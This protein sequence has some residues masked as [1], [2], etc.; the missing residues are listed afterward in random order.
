M[1]FLASPC[2]FA[3][4]PSPDDSSTRRQE[5]W[6]FR[7]PN[8]TDCSCTWVDVVVAAAKLP[9]FLLPLAL[10][11]FPRN[12]CAYRLRQQ[13]YGHENSHLEIRTR[14]VERMSA[15]LQWLR[16]RSICYSIKW[17]IANIGFAL[18]LRQ[19]PENFMSFIEV[20]PPRP[21]R[22]A[23]ALSDAEFSAHTSAEVE[24][25]YKERL[26]RMGKSGTYGD[27]LEIQAFVN[28]YDTCVRI[29]QRDLSYLIRP[30]GD[31]AQGA[32]DQTD[33]PVLYIAHHVR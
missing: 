10:H 25:A 6:E 1:L 19:H 28:E 2:F 3:Q 33:R 21:R 15:F 18:D 27:N 23:K 30:T 32:F 16:T 12:R 31:R 7:L 11:E 29:F 17:L 13:L 20:R 9:T 14:V 22:G 4:R 26:A 24:R 8:D 5:S